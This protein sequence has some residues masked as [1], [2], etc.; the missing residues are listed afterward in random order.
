MR[1]DEPCD[2]DDVEQVDLHTGVPFLVRHLEDRALRTVTRAVDN[3]IDTAPPVESR[4][5]KPLEIIGRLIRAGYPDTTE[6]VG[7]RFAFAG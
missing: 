7:E 1:C 3:R 2:S 4:L 5:D 6:F